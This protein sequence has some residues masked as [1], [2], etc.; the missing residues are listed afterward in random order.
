M[1]SQNLPTIEDECICES[2]ENCDCIEN[3]NQ[4]DLQEVLITGKSFIEKT[5]TIQES[6]ISKNQIEN[7]ADKSLGDLLNTLSGVSSLNS[8]NTVVKPIINGLH[9]SRVVI[10]N[11]GVRMQ[12][13]DWG[14]E[15]AP[16]IDINA[17]D[18]ITLIKG[19]SAL[20]YSGDAVGGLIILEP[21][22]F[23]IK[24]TIFGSSILKLSTNGRGG[25]NT[26]NFNQSFKSGLYYSI[27]STLKR[28]GDFESPNY[29]LSNT[30]SNESDFSLRFGLNKITEGFDIY[31]SYYK[32]N[33]GIHKASHLHSPSDQIRAIKSEFPIFLNDFTYKINNP[34]QDVTHKLF[35]LKIFKN[36][37][38][39]GRLDLQYNFQRND[40]FEYDI[41]LG[42]RG[43]IP[44]LDL[45]LDTHTLIVDLKSTL[46]NNMNLK[47]GF[48]LMTQNNFPDPAT[49][50]KR[51]IPDYD[52]TDFGIYAILDYRLNDNLIFELGSRFDYSYMDVQKYYRISLWESRNYHVLYGNLEKRRSSNSVLTNPIKKYKNLSSVLGLNYMLN[53]TDK[54]LLNYSV[55]VRPPNPSELFSEGL[56]HSAARI[57]LGDLTFGPETSQKISFLF[58]RIK[59]KYSISINPYINKI[60][61]FIYIEPTN[62]QQ[63]IRGNFQIWSYQQTDAILTGIDIDFNKLI[64]Q[65]FSFSNQLSYVRGVDKGDDDYLINM[66]PLNIRSEL[67]YENKQIKNF[68][69]SLQSEFVGEQKNYPDHSFKVYIPL[70]ETYE[71][72]DLGKPPALS[73]VFNLSTSLRLKSFE[74]SIVD[75][76]FSVTNLFN[77]EYKNYLNRLRYYQ[78]ELGRNISFGLK[79]SF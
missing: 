43:S 40:R 9:S 62:L 65:N 49:G 8:G 79:Y 41:R 68:T 44:S 14:V 59:P 35:R 74:K 42:G 50:V 69:L 78:H 53:S 18:N 3:I 16:N 6:R 38:N 39:L 55:A 60:D 45:K 29:I 27:Q 15:H 64:N 52:K 33:L 57:E 48:N 10:M 61:D 63:T 67:I 54:I 47:T 24:D 26:T 12:D 75:M 7:F 4:V 23:Q 73:H 2:Q 5:K 71:T 58:Q 1:Y 17:V 22:K 77:L 34:R 70:S 21:R 56:H 46:N 30:G 36:I 76:S 11:H 72:L 13:Q 28:F 25:F 20:K 32:N 19:A 37:I 51:I 66:P 31:F